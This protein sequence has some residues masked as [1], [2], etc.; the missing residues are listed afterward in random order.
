LEDLNPACRI[1][2]KESSLMRR[3][4]SEWSKKR[5]SDLITLVLREYLQI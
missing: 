3:V 1:V 5:F 4:L 2:S